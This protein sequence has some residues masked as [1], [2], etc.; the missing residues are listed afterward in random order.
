MQ[1]NPPVGFTLTNM[2]SPQFIQMAQN[3]A[4]T[5]SAYPAPVPSYLPLNTDLNSANVAHTNNPMYQPYHF[6]HPQQTGIAPHSGYCNSPQQPQQQDHQPW[7]WSHFGADPFFPDYDPQALN[8][9]SY[10][11]RS[12]TPA[13][14]ASNSPVPRYYPVSSDVSVQVPPAAP[15]V[16]S[17]SE[18]E[19]ISDE[20]LTDEFKW[21]KY[22]QKQVKG[23]NYPRNYYKCTVPG[24]T[25]KK[26]LE[27]FFDETA[28]KERL[29]TI[30]IGS[31]VHPTSPSPHLFVNNQQDF[32]NSVLAQSAKLRHM[33][34]YNAPVKSE[35]DSLSRNSERLLIECADNVDENEDGYFWRKYGQ[36]SV[37]GSL[38]P[39][40]YYRCR[41]VDCPVKKQAEISSQGRIILTYEGVHN[42]E[43]GTIPVE[44][45]Q[46]AAVAPAP[47]YAPE[48]QPDFKVDQY[49]VT[50]SPS[51][52]LST[53]EDDDDSYSSEP[54]PK[55]SKFVESD[56]TQHHYFATGED[57]IAST[58]LEWD[59]SY[60]QI[61]G[62]YYL[63]VAIPNHYH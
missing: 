56:N 32:R 4:L 57:M 34:S 52:T 43:A 12:F 21:R 5:N 39:R 54:S 45:L 60:P 55:R 8:E 28:N 47:Q 58:K 16:S 38:A 51:S 27:K 46:T 15:A 2:A 50:G 48:Q 29:R 18:F 3:H 20:P 41:N 35:E 9:P 33:S 10:A 7:N 42:H 1:P 63:D 30:Y 62:D 11:P 13:P 6:Q 53:T 22:G 31:H 59:H 44:D 61:F 26:H 40:Q 17:S 36:K 37:K 23:S 19:K 24:C 14:P 49:P 25:A